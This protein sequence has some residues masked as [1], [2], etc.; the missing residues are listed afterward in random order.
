MRDTLLQ[1]YDIDRKLQL[2]FNTVYGDITPTDW[3]S[4]LS[5]TNTEDYE[6]LAIQ[7]SGLSEHDDLFE[8][9]QQNAHASP[10]SININTLIESTDQQQVVL[11]HTSG[12][13]GGG[14]SKLKWLHM[15]QDIV[16]RLWAP[17]MQAIFQ[18][19]G[20]NHKSKV[21]I[22]V[23]GRLQG[24]GLSQIERKNVI[25][26]YSSEFSQRLVLALIT[27]SAYVLD[28]YRN[29]TDL[30]T[31]AH[32]L[33]LE[34]LDV[35]SAPATT[36]MKWASI[37]QLQKGI[38][39]SYRRYTQNPS[40]SSETDEIV[41]TIQK[42]GIPAATVHIQQQLKKLLHGACAIFGISSL[43]NPQWMMIREFMDWQRGRE[44]LTNLYVG[45][46]IGPFAANLRLDF[47]QGDFTT[48]M[49]I[50]PLS[51]VAIEHRG[52]RE[53]ISQSQHRR[54]KLLISRMDTTQPIF[55]L[56]PG[57]II[58]ITSQKGLPRI[59]GVLLRE[60]F[61]L[62]TQPQL[63]AALMS[64]D[65]YCVYVGGYF[66]L[67][68]LEIVN[69]N[70]IVAC[71]AEKTKNQIQIPMILQPGK[72]RDTWVLTLRI[73]PNESLNPIHLNFSK[74][75]QQIA[76]CLPD[77]GLKAALQNQIL[78]IE[79]VDHPLTQD[80]FS[81]KRLLN[82]VRRGRLPKGVLKKWPLYWIHPTYANAS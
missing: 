68:D 14:I 69:P 25:R 10:L 22:F 51:L 76:S 77:K 17:G 78:K 26:L 67:G 48:E 82:E 3:K 54:G 6:A 60:A 80:S 7:L 44:R 71:I 58:R 20:L 43:T 40:V 72:E 5:I 59:A 27:P 11:C 23:P 53:L 75:Q 49:R 46:E 33:A 45:S 35:I 63:H 36:L 79:I 8:K 74:F 18:T 70:Q 1:S 42:M 37:N 39:R 4:W 2:M 55:N 21:A 73:R 61:P 47:T 52:T 31:I 57:D 29:V 32:L 34:H 30:N 62:K 66:D 64:S 65:N 38:R 16:R 19:S 50:F 13:S 28:E 41:L 9:I 81:R 15:S 12:T 56:D 24:D